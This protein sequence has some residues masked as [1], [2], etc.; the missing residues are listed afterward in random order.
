R[1]LVV[2]SFR[3]DAA[4]GGAADQFHSTNL[5][6]HLVACALLAFVAAR[7]GASGGA[8]VL[9]AL[10]WGLAPRLTESVAW[11]SGRTDVFAGALVLAAIALSPDSS[12]MPRGPS[13]RAWART[14]A[15]A[16]CLFGAL[17]SK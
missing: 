5:L 6:V 17:L 2:A 12:A 9:A 15:S 8:A 14:I 4:L 10:V 11:I 16:T 3:F 7:A 13:A 1:P